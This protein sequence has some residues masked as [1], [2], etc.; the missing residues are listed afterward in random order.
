VKIEDGK[1]TV[2]L[3][4]VAGRKI[5]D[6]VALVAEE[7]RAKIIVFAKLAVAHGMSLSLAEIT[8]DAVNVTFTGR[9]ARAGLWLRR[10]ARA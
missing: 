8:M 1:A 2:G 10:V 9:F 4:V 5:D 7:A 3:F 6:E